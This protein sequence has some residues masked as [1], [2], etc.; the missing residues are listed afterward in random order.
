MPQSVESHPAAGT[1]IRLCPLE[2]FAQRTNLEEI[3]IA[4]LPFAAIGVV[5]GGARVRLTPGGGL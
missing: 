1:S 3:D 4:R 5:V 2:L